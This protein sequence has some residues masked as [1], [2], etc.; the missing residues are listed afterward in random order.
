MIGIPVEL[1]LGIFRQVQKL[2][3]R[4]EFE[5]APA[6]SLFLDQEYN[7]NLLQYAL[8]CKE[9]TAIAQSE[10]FKNPLL[11]DRTQTR[12]FLELVRGSA[13]FKEYAVQ[14]TSLKLGLSHVNYKVDGLSGDL[15]EIAL[16]CPNLVEISCL[17][18]DV[19]LEYFRVSFSLMHSG[20]TC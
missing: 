14:S 9:W 10:L 3:G 6:Q 15:D 11:R 17:R 1:T 16:Y 8:A 7:D 20:E 13:M 12:R 5:L 19:R 18:L 2:I 4:H